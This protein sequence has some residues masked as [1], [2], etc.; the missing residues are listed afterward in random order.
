M[1]D[2]LALDGAG[3]AAVEAL[4]RSVCRWVEKRAAT[5]G[6]DATNP[7]NPGMLGW[8]VEEGQAQIFTS[9]QDESDEIKLSEGSLMVPL[10][11]LSFVVGMGSGVLNTDNPCLF[12]VLK[13]NCRY[14][15]QHAK[16]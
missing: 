5:L 16:N 12:C 7:L 15:G 10:K 6:L 9:L 2:G 8:P 3:N 4:A 11:S 1:V 14:Q 13:G